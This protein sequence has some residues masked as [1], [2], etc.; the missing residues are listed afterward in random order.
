MDKQTLWHG[1]GWAVGTE[2]KK[3]IHTKHGIF[4]RASN[5][6]KETGMR[7]K[8]SQKD[9]IQNIA[10]LSLKSVDLK[11]KQRIHILLYC[12]FIYTTCI[13]DNRMCAVH[14]YYVLYITKIRAK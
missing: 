4:S 11:K 1:S 5:I 14:R 9:K 6:F 2:K 12:M 8:T 10:F 3:Q 13:K 7:K